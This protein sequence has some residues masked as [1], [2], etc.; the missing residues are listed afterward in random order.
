MR[1]RVIRFGIIGCGMISGWHADSIR[2]IPDCVLV[3][4]TDRSPEAC[5]AFA[6][7]Y[8]VTA[9][10]SVEALLGCPDIDVVCVCT[11]SGLHAPLCIQAAEA[12]KNIVTE[13]PMALTVAD[14]DAVIAA[15]ERNHVKMAV[16]SQLRFSHAIRSAAEA[17]HSGTLGQMLCGDIYM[18][19]SRTPD[20]YAKSPWR[21]TWK[22]DG[23]GALMNQGVHGVDILCHIMGPVEWVCGNCKTM[24]HAIETEDTASALVQFASGAMG[25]IEGTTSV[26]PGS[27][28]RIELNGT[29]GTIVLLED[30]VVEWSVEGTHVPVDILITASKTESARDPAKIGLEG[31]VAQLSD[32][33][34]AVRNDRSPMI[35]QYEGRKPVEV[36]C[37]IYESS[38]RGERVYLKR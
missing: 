18:K 28:R 6:A 31:H 24:V 33:A 5:A 21:G 16:I 35:D 23:G 29:R 4:A 9:F 11:P 7:K 34:D 19:Y 2:S 36:I 30:A 10:E 27:G 1:Q 32:M 8:G 38:R 20:Y 22:M 25:V 26:V 3:G 15:V 14:C 13:K 12:G 37:A 17:V